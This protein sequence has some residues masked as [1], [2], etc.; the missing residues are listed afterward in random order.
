MLIGSPTLELYVNSWNAKY[1]GNTIYTATRTGM[2]DSIGWGY[3]VGDAE[4]PTSTYV[5]RSNSDSLYYPHTSQYESCN[6]YWLASPSA[7]SD[8]YVMVVGSNGSVY[9]DYYY[10][11]NRAFRPVVCLPSNIF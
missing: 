9:N 2:T 5:S 4:N 6:G 10:G 1:S 7:T 3:Y 11:T 8:D